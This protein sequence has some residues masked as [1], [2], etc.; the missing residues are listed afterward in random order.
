MAIEIIEHGTLP[1]DKVY[2]AKCFGCK[3]KLRFHQR[4]GTLVSDQRDG[5]F[6]QITC[7]VCQY[8]VCTNVL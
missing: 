5:D 7:P 1:G 4:D 3:S 2:E 8:K 6:V